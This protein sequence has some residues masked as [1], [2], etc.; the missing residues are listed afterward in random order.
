MG[1]A[2]PIPMRCRHLLE[3]CGFVV[4]E[5]E[6]RA[7]AIS[8]LQTRVRV[9]AVVADVRWTRD[10]EGAPPDPAFLAILSNAAA[11]STEGSPASVVVLTRRAT[12]AWVNAA[13]HACGAHALHLGG[14]APNYAELARLLRDLRGLA[15][16][17]CA[18]SGVREARA[19]S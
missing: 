12:P 1:L 3:H 8:T 18:P 10:L 16:G 4:I 9:D 2:R 11:P 6:R 14:A 19:A 5:L 13:S 15:P 17:C 7:D